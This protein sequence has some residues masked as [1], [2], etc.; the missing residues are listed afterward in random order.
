MARK[1]RFR[2]ARIFNLKIIVVMLLFMLIVAGGLL[3]VDINK[4]YVLYG[5]TKLELIKIEE[6]DQD[7]YQVSLL[8][9]KFY[10]NLKYLNRDM[11]KL[12]NIFK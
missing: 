9:D 1:L 4:S 11:N 3:A 12:K 5:Q 8:N 10:L 7:I 2:N 6:V